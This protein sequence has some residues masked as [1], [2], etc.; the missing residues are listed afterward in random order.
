MINSSYYQIEWS[1]SEGQAQRKFL[2][3]FTSEEEV[4]LVEYSALGK[5]QS[6]MVGFI[7][8]GMGIDEWVCE[9]LAPEKSNI[10][11]IDEELWPYIIG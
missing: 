8:D 11:P 10:T 3:A 6:A 4:L 2:A 5:K 9:E 1:D 7:P